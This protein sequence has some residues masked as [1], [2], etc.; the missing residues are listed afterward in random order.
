MTSKPPQG[1]KEWQQTKTSFEAQEHFLARI[2]AVVKAVARE[3]GNRLKKVRMAI[4]QF[5]IV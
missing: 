1:P 3:T 4:L 2:V 5:L